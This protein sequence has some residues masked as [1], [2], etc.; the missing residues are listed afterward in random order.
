MEDHARERHET[1]HLEKKN[2]KNHDAL[3]R[4]HLVCGSSDSWVD[5]ANSRGLRFC[6]HFR[7]PVVRK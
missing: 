3:Q 2:T 6:F 4:K 1:K 7:E 5:F